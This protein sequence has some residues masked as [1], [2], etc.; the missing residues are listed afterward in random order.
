MKPRRG[1]VVLAF[2]LAAC[3]AVVREPGP[4]P[5]RP[6]EPVHT[7]KRESADRAGTVLYARND[8]TLTLMATFRLFD[9]VNVDHP[10][11]EL[12]ARALEPGV[13]VEVIT[14]RQVNPRR[15]HTFNFSFTA[16]PQ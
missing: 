8:T 7:W 4:P 10:C 15:D 5:P 2:L 11:G 12:P 13:V 16:R 14:V 6:G 1:V 3:A 9:C